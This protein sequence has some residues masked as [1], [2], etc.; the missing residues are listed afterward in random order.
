MGCNTFDAFG[1]N[2]G[3]NRVA[4]V[5]EAQD[6]CHAL[7]L[8]NDRQ[9]ADFQLPHM[10]HRLGEVFVFAAAMDLRRHDIARSSLL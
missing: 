1:E 4:D 10:L 8:V 2:V 6:A 5:A 9:P 3:W 7:A